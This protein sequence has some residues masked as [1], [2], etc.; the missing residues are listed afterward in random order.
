MSG[1]K[2]ATGEPLDG[3][4]LAVVLAAAVVAAR[5][6]GLRHPVVTSVLQAPPGPAAW[7]LAGRLDATAAGRRLQRRTQSSR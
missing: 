1:A 4:T 3:E 2:D 5:R 6:R 7:A